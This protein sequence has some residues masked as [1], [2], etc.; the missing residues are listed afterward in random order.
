MDQGLFA[1]W[2]TSLPARTAILEMREGV[3]VGLLIVKHSEAEKKLC[4]LRVRP[5]CESVGLDVR[6]FEAAFEL[7]DTR[8][9]LL[10]IS[11]KARP[12]FAR[13]L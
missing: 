11:E 9:P 6:L 3:V 8:R 1:S 2:R 4:T 12:K 5:Q 13:L 7:L 10:S